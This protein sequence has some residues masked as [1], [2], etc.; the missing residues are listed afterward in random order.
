MASAR[1]APADPV[2]RLRV[3][4]QRRVRRLISGSPEPPAHDPDRRDPGLFGPDSAVWRVHADPAMFVGGLRALLLQTMHPLAMAGVAEHSD[5]RRDPLGRLQRTAGFLGMT[6]YGTTADAEAAIRR[7]RAVHARVRGT[8]PDGRP[9]RA[10]DPHLVGWVH[11]TEVDSFLAAYQRYAACPLT[12]D[13]ADRYVAEMAVI[14]RKL[15]A[16]SPPR[17]R[18]ALAATLEAYRPELHVGAQ[19]RDGVRFLL[20]PPLPL[21]ARPAYS[22]ITGAAVALLP[23]WARRQLWL[24][25]AP[26]ADTF[27]VRPAATA[28]LRVLGWALDPHLPAVDLEPDATPTT[29]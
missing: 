27:V 3:G 7:V 9:Y 4:L 15:G 14:A 21:A 6:T 10:Q 24:P 19:A 22:I 29:S 12:D 28:L 20:L 16:K 17:S 1:P 26:G 8:A 23:S 18:A 2:A 5:Y 13:E 11:A 25:L